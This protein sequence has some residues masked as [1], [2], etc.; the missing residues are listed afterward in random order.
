VIQG[1]ENFKPLS[2]A[3]AVATVGTFDGIHR[4]HQEIFRRVASESSRLGMEPVL[5]T[6]HPHPRVVVSPDNIPLLLTTIEEKQ[7]FLKDFYAGQVLLLEFNKQLQQ[8]TAEEFVKK[9]L[10]ETVRARKMIIGYDHALGKNRGGG[11]VELTKL[12]RD[13][14]F[15]VEVVGPIMDD[16][17]PISSSRV[18]RALQ[19]NRLPEAIR[20]LGHGYAIAGKVEQGIGL[21]HK[22]GFPT[23]NVSYNPRKLLPTEGV[24]SCWARIGDTR[25]DGMMFIGRNH[26]NPQERISV[27]AN[28]FDFDESLYGR[29]M[30]VY[31]THYI[32]EN[33]RF[34]NVDDLKRQIELDKQE[35]LQIIEK[36]RRN[37]S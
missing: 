11:V 34:E 31:P 30:I 26:F 17:Q 16:G 14:G 3:G 4:G 33:R 18:R 32:R 13:Y 8:W 6:F 27:E 35:I 19:A 21:G 37:A 1:F 2:T 9:I 7:I 5:I 24:Y 23:A 20:L 36:E 25:R 28:L 22:I 29:E 10:V 15:E 12:G